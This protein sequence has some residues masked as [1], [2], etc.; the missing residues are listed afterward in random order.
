LPVVMGVIL[1]SIAEN[2]FLKGWLIAGAGKGL[3]SHFFTGPINV[4]IV[5]MCAASIGYG[6]YSGRKGERKK[7]QVGKSDLVVSAVIV[8]STIL[9]YGSMKAKD[10]LTPIFPAATLIIMG[11]LS[12]LL[13]ILALASMMAKRKPV[14]V[15]PVR[16]PFPRIVVT[17]LLIIGYLS[18]LNILGFYFTAFVFYLVFASVV[19]LDR[20]VIFS[21]LRSRILTSALFVVILF[22]LFKMLLKV[23]TPTGLAF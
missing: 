14:E 22:M 7:M 3:L 9:V 15:S 23:Q 12:L 4:I 18:V 19:A 21:R 10:P 2:S 16:F 1:G 11:S 8:V 6:I 20:E 13:L 17:G 5:L